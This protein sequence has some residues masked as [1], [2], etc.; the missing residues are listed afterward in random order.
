MRGSKY[1]YD[2]IIGDGAANALIGGRLYPAVVPI[3]ATRP[4][5]AYQTISSVETL[6]HDGGHGRGEAHERVQIT[7]VAGSYA[8]LVT[9]ANAAKA[10]VEG[11]PDAPNAADIFTAWQLNTVDDFGQNAG[12]YILRQDFMIHLK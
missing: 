10:A 2:R 11:A 6:T 12:V 7:W 9:L 5:G 4:A 8:E 3:E 1:V